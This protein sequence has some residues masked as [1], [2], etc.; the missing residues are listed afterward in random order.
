MQAMQQ[1]FRLVAISLLCGG[2]AA[3]AAASGGLVGQCAD[4]HT[5]HNSAAG[6]PV[7]LQYGKTVADGTR[8]Q[9]LLKFDCLAC[10]AQDPSGT[11]IAEVGQGSLVPQ[12]Y[13]GDSEDLA[14][15]N[16]KHIADSGNRKGHNV[17]DFGFA[18]ETNI[19]AYGSPPGMYYASVHGS[20]FGGTATPYANFTCA[21]TV[22]CHGTRSQLLAG[23]T[24]LNGGDG[25]AASGSYWVNTAQREGIAAVSGAHHNSYDGAKDP[26]QVAVN[27]GAHDGQAL[28]DSYRFIRG[29]KGYGNEAARWQNVDSSNHNEYY[30]VA[31]LPS[32]GIASETGCNTCH[33]P[34]DASVG[35]SARKTFDS[36]LRVPNQSM[37]GFCVTCHGNFHSS[38]LETAS[39]DRFQANGS[40][41]AFLRHP[42]DYVI[43]S[44]GE[45]ANYTTYDVGAPVARPTL[46]AAADATVNPGTDMVMCL[47]CHVAHAS[48]HDGMLRFDYAAQTSLMRA[49]SFASVAEAQAAGGC[50]ACHTTKG[51]LPQQR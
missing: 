36:S 38:G 17:S 24:E 42:S 27:G 19:D 46:Y 4:C 31:G 45:Y 26:A 23:T 49:G 47:S 8:N 10:H 13:H 20:Y 7:A 33:V 41:G 44:S 51:V 28:A 11:K 2:V 12:V 6:Q 34:G 25:S 39:N 37:S 18:A 30:G 48:P 15:G 32:S 40:S 29:L 5:M 35:G 3:T 14:A 22:G 43:P 50:L 21:G 9:N 16:F 1:I